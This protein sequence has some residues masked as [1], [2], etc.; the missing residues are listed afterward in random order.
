MTGLQ[1]LV[2]WYDNLDELVQARMD[3]NQDA[4]D[5]IMNKAR[6]LL[7]EEQANKTIYGYCPKCGADVVGM[8]RRIN[9]DSTCS[10]GHKFP[11]K[12]TVKQANKPV[13]DE[14]LE[15]LAKRKGHR[16]ELAGWLYRQ[17]GSLVVQRAENMAA[18]R[19]Y[20]NGLDDKGETK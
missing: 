9:G 11:S 1:K 14:P 18:L 6:S 4:A 15:E 8:E 12:D 13:E 16:L 10:N 7:A 5:K 17:D 20:L 19:A 3:Y 2:E